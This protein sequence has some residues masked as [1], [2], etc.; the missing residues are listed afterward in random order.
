MSVI[1]FK[2]Y[3]I[4]AFFICFLSLYNLSKAQQVEK[5]VLTTEEINHHTHWK[6]K[7][8]AFLGDSMTDKKRIGTNYIYWEYLRDMLSIE[9][10]VYGVNGHQWSGIYQQA[11]QLKNA[12]IRDLHA[13]FIFAGT[14]DY[15]ANVPLGNFYEEDLKET[16]YNGSK[17]ERIFRQKLL[18]DNTFCGRIN[19][20][21]GFLKE[22]F[23]EQQ[24]IVLT[25]IHRGYAQFGEKNIQPDERF[26]NANGNTI[27]EFVD[28][29]QKASA[30]WSVPV[31]NLYSLSGLYPM[32]NTHQRYFTNGKTD[33]LHPNALGHY[34]IAK[35]LYYQ[36]LQLP[37]SFL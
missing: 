1:S 29:L 6:G 13:I 27:S 17:V 22:H 31:I 8:V 18:L 28:T 26:A 35:S 36:L 3:K 32:S 15:M 4:I 20:V 21:L 2:P 9:P 30:V 7:K 34:R 19:R 14:N 10:F 37:S 25:P 16:N 5:K 23:P 33:M 24:I 11:E 12:D